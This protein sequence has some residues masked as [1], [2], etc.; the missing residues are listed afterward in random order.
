MTFKH[1]T[2]TLCKIKTNQKKDAP[3][4]EDLNL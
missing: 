3:E 1:T 4:K 2:I